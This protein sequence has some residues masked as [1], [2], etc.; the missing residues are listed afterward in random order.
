M[1]YT[2]KQN[3]A[4]EKRKENRKRLGLPNY[5][6]GEEIFS[7]ISH[8]LGVVAGVVSLII[9]LL[10]CQKTPVVISSVSIFAGTMI[11]LY[12]VSTLYHA[13]GINKAKK[14]FRVLDHCTI[15]LLIAGTYTPI[16]LVGLGGTKGIIMFA[17]V[18]AAAILGIILNAIDL[19]RF[20]KFSMVCYIAMGWVIIFAMKDFFVNVGTF[21]VV[22]LGVGGVFYTVGA[23]LYGLGKKKAYIHSVWHIFV[24]A[25]SVCHFITVLDIVK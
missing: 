20:A 6:L 14:V 7:A 9:L 12:T 18:W 5:S 3:F 17:V 2:S 10:A 19:K 15:F 4:I 24:L 8:G 11:L 16:T 25:G 21:P 23:V 22:M 1:T 13:L